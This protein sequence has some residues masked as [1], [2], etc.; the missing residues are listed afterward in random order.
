MNHPSRQPVGVTA[1]IPQ[2]AKN[3]RIVDFMDI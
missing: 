3:M 2:I 1:F